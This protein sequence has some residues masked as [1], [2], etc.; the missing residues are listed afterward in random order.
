M[1]LKKHKIIKHQW[2]E[3]KIIIFFVILLCY[4]WNWSNF[5]SQTTSLT[6][7]KCTADEECAPQLACI[8]HQCLN[9]CSVEN[10]CHYDQQCDVQAHKAVCF[11]GKITKIFCFRKKLITRT[12]LQLKRFYILF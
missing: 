3:E 8:K 2:N 7:A 1:L 5:F 12:L 6:E 11:S 10:P 4:S 9:P